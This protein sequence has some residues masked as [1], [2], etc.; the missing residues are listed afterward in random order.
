MPGQAALAGRQR[1]PGPRPQ[2]AGATS[3][4]RP[5]GRAAPTPHGWLAGRGGV[6]GSLSLRV[7]PSLHSGAGVLRS[8]ASPSQQHWRLLWGGAQLLPG[9]SRPG[10]Q[11]L[12]GVTTQR[13]RDAS[14]VPSWLQSPAAEGEPRCQHQG[15]P[16]QPQ[17]PEQQHSVS[18]GSPQ[19]GQGLLPGAQEGLQGARTGAPSPGREAAI[20]RPALRGPS[21]RAE[22]ASDSL[23]L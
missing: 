14:S 21:W 8:G 7:G 5:G 19:P 1:S 13:G 2:A 18:A 22:M 12:V 11:L 15:V 10:F 23:R 9:P 4:P 3:P 17:P 16:T 6:G 20:Y